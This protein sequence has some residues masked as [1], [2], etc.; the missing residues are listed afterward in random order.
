MKALI[1]TNE[2]PPYVYGGSAEHV[3]PELAP[4][5]PLEVRCRGKPEKVGSRPTPSPWSNH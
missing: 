2:Y 4:L 3:D 1:L 5:I